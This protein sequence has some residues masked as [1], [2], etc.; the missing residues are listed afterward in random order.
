MKSGRFRL[1]FIGGAGDYFSVVSRLKQ[2]S[3]NIPF[4]FRSRVLRDVDLQEL[5]GFRLCAGLVSLDD[6]FCQA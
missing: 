6:K 4:L 3:K 5:E 1:L 2:L